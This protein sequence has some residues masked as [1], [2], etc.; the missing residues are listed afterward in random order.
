MYTERDYWMWLTVAFGPA[1]A[2]KWN[3]VSHYGSVEAAYEALNER[4]DMSHVLPQDIQGIR[5]ACMEQ[6]EDLINYCGGSGIKYTVYGDD[7]YPQRLKEIY[8]PPTMLFYYG[9]ISVLDGPVISAV[10]TRKPEK[11]FVEAAEK[12]CAGLAARGVAIASGFAVG[13]DSVAHSAA[14]AAGGKTVAVLPCGILHDYPPE[15]AGKH[16]MLAMHGAVISEYFPNDPPSSL[17]FRARNR[18]LSGIGLGTLVLQT[19]PKGGAL[20]TASFA[21]S[22]GRDIFC[23]P[24]LMFDTASAGVIPL[25][26][27]GAIPVFDISDVLNEY[28]GGIKHK[29]PTESAAKTPPK[30]RPAPPKKKQTERPLGNIPPKDEEPAHAD[31][32]KQAEKSPSDNIAA[33]LDGKKKEIYELIRDNSEIHLDSIA[34]GIGDINELEAYLTELELEGLIRSLPGNR[35]T[36]N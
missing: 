34:V 13:L 33:M 15:N 11:Y 2:R 7:D 6:V 5:T 16:K 18:I 17:T 35:F 10:G 14:I 29:L 8:N 24:P 9:D 3:A 1:N 4:R 27:D 26:R 21:L 23:I 19:G 20:S 12:I 31:E 36:V 22:Q 32:E 25:L 28:D 30:P